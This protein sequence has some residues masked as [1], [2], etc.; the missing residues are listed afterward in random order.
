MGEIK[1]RETNDVEKVVASFLFTPPHYTS[2]TFLRI[3]ISR[4]SIAVVC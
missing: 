3:T 4:N 2:I 1:F